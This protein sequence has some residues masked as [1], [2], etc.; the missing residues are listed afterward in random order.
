MNLGV[1]QARARPCGERLAASLVVSLRIAPM[2]RSQ[3]S[4]VRGG[5][6]EKP[7]AFPFCEGGQ[8]NVGAGT[9][10][11]KSAKLLRMCKIC[12]PTDAM[13]QPRNQ[14]SENSGMVSGYEE[15]SSDCQM[16]REE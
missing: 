16:R 8:S 10:D 11:R 2:S 3:A 12:S 1:P 13:R 15:F 6:G 7:E 4:S 5:S 14:E 9:G